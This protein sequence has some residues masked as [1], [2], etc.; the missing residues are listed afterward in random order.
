M[1]WLTRALSLSVITIAVDKG[2][3][4]GDQAY[5]KKQTCGAD[6]LFTIA[7]ISKNEA[8]NLI[9]NADLREKGGSL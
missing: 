4:S 2:C 7:R 3:F 6:Y 1:P 8:I 9:R 5:I